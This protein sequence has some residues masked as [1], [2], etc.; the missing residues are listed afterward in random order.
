MAERMHEA[1][2]TACGRTVRIVYF[3]SEGLRCPVPEVPRIK[4]KVGSWAP[5]ELGDS[6][7]TVRAAYRPARIRFVQC[8]GTET[9]AD[10]G[11]P[12]PEPMKVPGCEGRWDPFSVGSEDIAVR[13]SY[14]GPGHRISL[15]A[16][17]NPVAEVSCPPGE[18]PKLPQVPRKRGYRGRWPSFAPVSGR[19][20]VE[21]VYEPVS[22]I[23]ET[24]IGKTAAVPF[25][26]EGIVLPPV[27]GKPGFAGRWEDFVPGTSDIR[28]KPV[29]RRVFSGIPEEN[30]SD[31]DREKVR[32]ALEDLEYVSE[33]WSSVGDEPEPAR[34]KPAYAINPAGDTD[35]EAGWD[36]FAGSLSPFQKEYLA[37]LAGEGSGP[38]AV[39]GR[40][41]R[42][43]AAAEAEIN[44]L[45]ES[46]LGDPIIDG[47]ELDPDYGAKVLEVLR[48]GS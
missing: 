44:A 17:G 40:Y 41:G 35:A 4:G 11:G 19:I 1:R 33:I 14:R 7:I 13:A 43:R 27:P 5:A 30:T 31:I 28:L 32:K 23:C 12:Y 37:S 21:A 9:E 48:D 2:F 47:G 36:G 25:D 6:D 26:P 24:G 18:F 20:A 22:V 34:E 16:D 38:D 42:M 10:A 29:Y 8:D 45:A 46:L 15:Y 3:D 39:L